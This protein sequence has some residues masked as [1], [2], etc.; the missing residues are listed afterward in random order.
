MADTRRVRASAVA[1]CSKVVGGA[2]STAGQ[3]TPDG[4]TQ[5]ATRRAARKLLAIYA[6]RHNCHNNG[7][8]HHLNGSQKGSALGRGL[9]M[10]YIVTSLYARD[11]RIKGRQRLFVAALFLGRMHVLGSTGASSVRDLFTSSLA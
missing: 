3:E 5:L 11:S 2:D 7:L 1:F 8:P 9:P 4:N 6:R 10:Q